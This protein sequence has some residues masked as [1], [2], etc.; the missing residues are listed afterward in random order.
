MRR[1]V[2]I[3]GFQQLDRLGNQRVVENNRAENSAFGFGAA[4]KRALKDRVANRFRRSHVFVKPRAIRSKQE[5]QRLYIGSDLIHCRE[6]YFLLS[7]VASFY[8]ASM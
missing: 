1:H 6:I 5:G 2:K 7:S 3:S 8:F 4:G